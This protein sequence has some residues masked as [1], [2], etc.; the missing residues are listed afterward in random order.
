MFNQKVMIYSWIRIYILCWRDRRLQKIG[1]T[2]QVPSKRFDSVDAKLPVDVVLHGVYETLDPPKTEKLIH[3]HFAELRK[4]G[5]W[6]TG[7]PEDFEQDVRRIAAEVSG[8][9]WREYSPV[10]DGV[11]TGFMSFPALNIHQ[12][13][14]P[15]RRY[16]LRAP[17][18]GTVAPP[19][20][21]G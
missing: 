2:Q 10:W 3:A 14:E 8:L 19:T 20:V 4:R 15:V 17:I 7:K 1:F 16:H 13:G 9:L 5:E 21:P 6:F 12:R 18:G 11:K